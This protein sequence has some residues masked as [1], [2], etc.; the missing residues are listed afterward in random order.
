MKG[1]DPD[2]I[3][4]LPHFKINSHQSGE[5]HLEGSISVLSDGE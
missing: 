2:E 4:K 3:F 1:L 5:R